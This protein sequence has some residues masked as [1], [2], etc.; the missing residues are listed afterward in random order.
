M[1]ILEE[2]LPIEAWS[3]PFLSRLYRRGSKLYLDP[4]CEKKIEPE[5]S[6]GSQTIDIEGNYSPR[7]VEEII[8]EKIQLEQK[9]NPAINA[10]EIGSI[11]LQPNINQYRATFSKYFISQFTQGELFNLEDL[12]QKEKILIQ[13]E[14]FDKR[15]YLYKIE[16]T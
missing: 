5:K 15:D 11:K 4:D 6:Y 1:A 13:K 10:Y 9:I 3:D 12:S 2:P 14:L 16:S 8:L 7:K